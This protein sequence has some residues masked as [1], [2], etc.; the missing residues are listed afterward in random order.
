ML[1]TER[2][3][4]LSELMDRFKRDGLRAEAV[5][6]TLKEAI[7]RGIFAEGERLQDRA[8]ALELGVSRTPVREALQR[9]ESQGF[10]ENRPRVGLAVTEITPQ[11]IEDIYVIRI[12]LEGVAAR[13][14]A[15]RASPTDLAMLDRINAQ[16]ADATRRGALEAITQL[17]KEF[18][19]TMYHAA[20]NPRLADLLKTLQDSV[21]RFARSTLSIPRRAGEALEEHREIL[22]AIR[23]RDPDHAERAARLHKEHAKLVRLGMYSTQ[24]ASSA[25]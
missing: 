22:E 20:R 8:L 7:A 21:Q 10:V 3:T 14:A 4:L 25:S 12:A 1:E 9:L 23:D 24:L 17:N 5:Y 2:S 13:L 15:Q 11:A 16:L 19:E 6:R 18:H